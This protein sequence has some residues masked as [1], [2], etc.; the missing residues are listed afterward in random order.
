MP[1][2]LPNLVQPTVYEEPVSPPA[3]GPA[4]LNS[5][6]AD[7]GRVA[8]ANTERAAAPI[9]DRLAKL[10]V[11]LDNAP[12]AKVTTPL[13]VELGKIATEDHVAD[14][15]EQRK[16]RAYS[17]LQVLPTD[18]EREIVQDYTHY[19]NLAHGRHD[20]RL[21]PLIRDAYVAALHTCFDTLISAH[22]AS[23]TAEEL[24][25][26]LWDVCDEFIELVNFENV[27]FFGEMNAVRDD[28]E[29]SLK[30]GDWFHHQP[31]P[32]P[33]WL[34]LASADLNSYVTA[35]AAGVATAEDPDVNPFVTVREASP[36]VE[37]K[38]LGW[39]VMALAGADDYV[40]EKARARA[41]T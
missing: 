3:P 19:L 39:V 38:H 24:K 2:S 13:I 33:F 21:A 40:V 17:V 37:H 16:N 31:K 36:D 18:F 15:V 26:Q 22:N 6:Q 32:L 28:F 41:S 25:F 30:Q 12:L 11:V 7:I 4:H 14:V 5:L 9:L 34:P 29:A 23:D 8:V 1:T 20:A 27:S 35:H 10:Y